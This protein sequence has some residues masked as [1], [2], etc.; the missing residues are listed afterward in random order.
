MGTVK[1]FNEAE[2]RKWQKFYKKTK[3]VRPLEY[4]VYFTEFFNKPYSSKV[5]VLQLRV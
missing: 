5:K 3:N 4:W 1:Y 2:V